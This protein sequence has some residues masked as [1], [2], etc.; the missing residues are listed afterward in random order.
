[1]ILS[2]FKDAALLHDLLQVVDRFLI[3]DDLRVELLGVV[4][5]LGVYLFFVLELKRLGIMDEGE[6]VPSSIAL[7]LVNDE[8]VFDANVLRVD[9][10]PILARKKLFETENRLVFSLLKNLL[11]QVW[12]VEVSICAVVS[13]AEL[14]KGMLDRV[15]G[16]LGLKGIES[17]VLLS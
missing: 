3:L 13:I 8:G 4:E 7:I 14:V 2:L 6:V 5:I 17:L 11:M 16:R 1:M 12:D 10:L 15:S 9:G